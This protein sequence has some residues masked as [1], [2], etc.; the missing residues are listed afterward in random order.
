MLTGAAAA[1]LLLGGAAAGARG[2]SGAAGAVEARPT[3]TVNVRYTGSVMI[4][5]VADIHVASRFEPEV[6][7]ATARFRTAGLASLFSSTDI[8]ANV[9]GYRNGRGLVPWRYQ[10]RNHAGSRNRLVEVNFPNGVAEP[11]INPPFGSMGDPPASPEER[12]GAMDPISALF[13]IALGATATNGELCRGRA[14]VFDGRARYNLRLEPGGTERVRTRAWSGD[15][16]VC[17]AF[18]EPVAG[19]EE[20]KRPTD[21]DIAQPIVMWLAPIN[22]GEMHFPV[23]F[24]ANAAYGGATIEARS[25]TVE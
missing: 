25:M 4:F 10:H 9:S 5:N 19:Y 11:N 15:A 20:G 8:E 22:G 12:A 1:A 17:R 24:R 23:R 7:R 21:A 14:P 2:V 16:V 6:Y 13:S 18:Y 3:A